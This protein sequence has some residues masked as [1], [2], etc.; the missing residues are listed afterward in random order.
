MTTSV[1][2]IAFCLIMKGICLSNAAVCFDF[3][4]GGV[5]YS[6]HLVAAEAYLLIRNSK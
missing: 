4:G 5:S 6:C 3:D 2:C 1:L